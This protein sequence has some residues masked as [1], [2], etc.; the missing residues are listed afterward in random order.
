MP[1]GPEILIT[2]QYLKTKLK[3][4][5]I[6]S[7]QVLSGRYTH[8][9]L[10]GL[11]LTKST[12]LTVDTIDSKGKFLWMKLVDKTG[13]SI[14]MMNTFGMTGRWSFR[15]NAS[16][17]LKIVIQSNTDPA[18]KYDLYFIDSRNFGTIEFTSNQQTLQ[19][20]IDKLAPDVLKTDMN[21]NDLVRLFRHFTSTSRKDKN[22]V[23]VLM[24]Q[25]AIVS[26][27]GNY[28]V[29][30]ILYDAKLDPHRSLTNLSDDEMKALAHSIR[31]IVKSAYYNNNSGYMEHFKL[32]MK[33]HSSRID[34]GVFP[35]YHPDI[36]SNKK[37]SFK[38]YQ[39]KQDPNGNDVENDEIVKDR[40]IHWVKAVQK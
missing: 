23:K 1:E 36:K 33:T 40:T 38:V 20:K 6:D 35:N 27:I 22:L 26:G 12:P 30:E 34:S 29:A 28:L 19:K 2:C 9:N 3:K 14:Y 17:R 5:K 13:K 39:Q 11:E 32:F 31:K 7:I 37:F 16:S 8:Q 10:K 4:K 25:E 24:D 21:D 18:K 15:K